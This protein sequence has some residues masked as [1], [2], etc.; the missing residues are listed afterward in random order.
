[1]IKIEA[2]R[3]ASKVKRRRVEVEREVITP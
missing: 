3:R 2:F 1:M